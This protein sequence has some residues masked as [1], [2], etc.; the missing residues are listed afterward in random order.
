MDVEGL[1]ALLLEERRLEQSLADVRRELAR[2]DVQWEMR[3]FTGDASVRYEEGQL[4]VVEA[5]SAQDAF[6]GP[7][8]AAMGEDSGEDL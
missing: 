6:S 3:P 1:R 4:V 7:A 8:G 5:G 2:W